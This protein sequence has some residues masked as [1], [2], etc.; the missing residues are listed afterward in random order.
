MRRG[1]AVCATAKLIVF[2]SAYRP[3][4]VLIPAFQ[5]NLRHP[6]LQGLATVGKCTW[7]VLP[8][9]ARFCNVYKVFDVFALGS[10]VRALRDSAFS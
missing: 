3:A 7:C 1:V 9:F 4:M 5:L 2:D 6:I 8:L 10:G